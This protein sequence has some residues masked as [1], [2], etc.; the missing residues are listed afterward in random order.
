MAA[1][2]KRIQ[3]LYLGRGDAVEVEDEVVWDETEIKKKKK[4]SADAVAG[5]DPDSKTGQLLA[6]SRG[7]LNKMHGD[8]RE[9]A[10]AIHERIE[11]AV[12][13]GDAKE[14]DQ[15]TDALRELLFFV[16]GQAG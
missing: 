2:R 3:E 6:R 13:S 10:I 5:L 14:L 11:S 8:D 7:L 16:E 9:E 12:E 1:A 4:A 15:A